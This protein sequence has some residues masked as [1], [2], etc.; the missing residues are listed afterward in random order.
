MSRALKRTSPGRAAIAEYDASLAWT[1]LVLLLLG[2]V[3]VYSASISLAEA[4]RY[5]GGRPAYFLARHAVFL[6][7]SILAGMLV[8]QVPTHLWQRASP[9]LFASTR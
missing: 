9:W 8:F 6:A 1:A 4:S 3:M 2:L 7:V 5:T